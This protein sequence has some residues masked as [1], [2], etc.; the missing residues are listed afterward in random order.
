MREYALQRSAIFAPK[1][2]VG[3]K[4][5]RT[6][7]TQMQVSNATVVDPVTAA[8]EDDDENERMIPGPLKCSAEEEGCMKRSVLVAFG[9]QPWLVLISI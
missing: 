9:E 7:P 3:V 5:Q 2:A 1:Q 6:P 8:S 4:R